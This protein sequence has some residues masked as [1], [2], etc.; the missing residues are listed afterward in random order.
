M[1]YTIA[2][3]SS[4]VIQKLGLG[5]CLCVYCDVTVNCQLMDKFDCV[6]MC[7]IYIGKL[8]VHTSYDTRIQNA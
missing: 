5:W 4:G 1:L 3:S 2:D 6:Y 8:N 7:Y